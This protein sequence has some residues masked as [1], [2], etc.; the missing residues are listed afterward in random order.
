MKQN[1]H[2]RLEHLIDNV[3]GESRSKFAK[4]MD[5]HPTL[6][7]NFL[8]GKMNKPS[9]GALEKMLF[10]R[11]ISV[12]WLISGIGPMFFLGHD[13]KPLKEIKQE[14][15]DD[16][17]VLNQILAPILSDAVPDHTI[18][19]AEGKP[20]HESTM[21][22]LAMRVIGGEGLARM[23]QQKLDSLEKQLSD[24]ELIIQYQ[25]NLLEDAGVNVGDPKS[26]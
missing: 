22:E 15:K 21:S 13:S 2:T 8:G 9:F 19:N 24:K 5:Y 10:E 11:N 1:V 16:T 23:L 17:E 25:T 4:S 18:P 3:L 12:N 7:N 20:L 26:S 6:V 14:V